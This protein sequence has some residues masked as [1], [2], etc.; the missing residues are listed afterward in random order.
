VLTQSWRSKSTVFRRPTFFK[1]LSRDYEKTTITAMHHGR[2][3][4]YKQTNKYF[5]F[6]SY[7]PVKAEQS[8]YNLIQLIT[9]IGNDFNS[10]SELQITIRK[11]IWSCLVQKGGENTQVVLHSITARFCLRSYYSAIWLPFWNLQTWSRHTNWM[12]T[13]THCMIGAT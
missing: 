7:T 11:K 1:H 3:F 2:W 9:F 10:N 13:A 4:A 12:M 5:Y 6:H 8:T